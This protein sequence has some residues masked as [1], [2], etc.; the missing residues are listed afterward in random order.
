[1][2]FT[3]MQ[4]FEALLEKIDQGLRALPATAQVLPPADDSATGMLWQQT[5]YSGQERC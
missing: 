4:D 5:M 1:L 2:W 3:L